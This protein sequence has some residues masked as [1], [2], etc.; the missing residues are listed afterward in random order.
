MPLENKTTTTNEE[1]E[2]IIS[3]GNFLGLIGMPRPTQTRRL[4][5]G[6][7][8][9]RRS[10]GWTWDADLENTLQEENVEM[11]DQE[12]LLKSRF[13]TKSR[14]DNDEN[15]TTRYL[16]WRNKNNSNT[17]V[18]NNVDI[19]SAQFDQTNICSLCLRCGAL[20]LTDIRKD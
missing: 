13:K 20:S 3:I 5:S 19:V 1:R 15:S 14:E 8:I 17:D 11:L 10:L 6:R 7:D 18:T 9:V 2:E 16:C 12:T 4:G